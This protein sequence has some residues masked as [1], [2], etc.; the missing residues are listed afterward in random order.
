MMNAQTIQIYRYPGRSRCRRLT[1]VARVLR[2]EALRCR[3]DIVDAPGSINKVK[4]DYV[5]SPRRI[6]AKAGKHVRQIC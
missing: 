1:K 2:A 6:T 5:V 3:T 4:F